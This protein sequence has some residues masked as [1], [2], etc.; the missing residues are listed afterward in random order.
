MKKILGAISVLTILATLL[1]STLAVSAT[2][3]EEAVRTV[4]SYANHWMTDQGGTLELVSGGLTLKNGAANYGYMKNTAD[5]NARVKLT[6]D[7]GRFGGENAADGVRFTI[8]NP[9]ETTDLIVVIGSAMA[10]QWKQVI[11]VE[12][13]SDAFVTYTCPLDRFVLEADN[14]GTPVFTAEDKGVTTFTAAAAAGRLI[15]DDYDIYE[16][17]FNILSNVQGRALTFGTMDIVSGGSARTVHTFQSWLLEGGSLASDGTGIALS[18]SAA[19]SYMKNHADFTAAVR[20]TSDGARFNGSNAIDALRVYIRNPGP[21]VAVHVLYTSAMNVIWKKTLWVE[22]N[23]DEYVAYDCRLDEL[24][25]ERDNKGTPVFTEEDKGVT[26]FAAAAAA[27]RLLADDYEYY[28]QAFNIVSTD[29]DC[30]LYFRALEAVNYPTAPTTTTTASTTTTTSS[31]ATTTTTADSATTTT[32]EQPAETTTTTSSAPQTEQRTERIQAWDSLENW[33]VGQGGTIDLSGGALTLKNTG[34]AYAFAANNQDFRNRVRLTRDGE[35]YTGSNG[36]DA[37]RL[38]VKNTGDAY[39][40]MLIYVDERGYTWKQIVTI[41]G[42][43]EE[44]VGYDYPLDNFLLENADKE[45]PKGTTRREMAEAGYLTAEN[46]PIWELML[47]MVTTDPA[48]TMSF[49]ELLKVYT[50]EVTEPTPGT[51][52]TATPGG[53]GPETGAD[54]LTAVWVLL[55]AAA[56][57]AALL[58]L[59]GKKREA[60]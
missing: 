8:R 14:K 49:G 9:G 17:A 23:S 35:A 24:M 51:G 43:S 33:R 52:T 39:D 44:F 18:N 58:G 42:A 1:I 5:F 2:E 36:I 3:P 41:A 19:Y 26:S 48:C 15:A 55:T 20:L 59:L 7:G 40:L 30:V 57:G 28:N 38:T 53:E 47:N 60:A 21:S 56:A 6:S 16:M 34:G 29:T 31:S 45:M 27:G 11:T 50:A 22:G 4:Y 32:T 46:W 10:V 54:G 12:G 37:L 25:L 13:H